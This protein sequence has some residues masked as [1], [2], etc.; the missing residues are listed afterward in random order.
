MSSG[1]LR[2]YAWREV[3]QHTRDAMPEERVRGL[4]GIVQEAG[5][6]ELLVGAESS[7]DARGL[8]RMTI[9]RTRR[10]DVPRR[11]AD[12]VEHLRRSRP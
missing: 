9:V 11:L 4:R 6:D 1:Q 3:E 5:D 12:P 10:A 7:K 2:A 8:R